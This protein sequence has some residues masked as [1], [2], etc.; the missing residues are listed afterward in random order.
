M[1][2][3]VDIPIDNIDWV[4]VYAAT[5]YGVGTG[6]S[7]QN[8]TNKT[9]YVSISQTKPVVTT[10]GFELQ[11]KGMVEVGSNVGGCWVIV[12]GSSTPFYG[13]ISIFDPAALKV[14]SSMPSDILTT[15][16]NGL[17][18]LKVDNTRSGFIAG[19]EFRVAVE[20]NIPTGGRKVYKIT[21]PIDFIL[22][23]QDLYVDQGGLKLTSFRSGSTTGVYNE[24]V[25]PIPK[26]IMLS[27]PQPPYTSQ[28]SIT[29][30]TTADFT[31]GSL[32]DIVRVRSS[33][34]TAQATS[35]GGNVAV[36]R[37]LAPGDYFI[38]V[39]ALEGVNSASR[40]VYSAVWE[41]RP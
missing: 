39:E 40:G 19:R 28:I 32:T 9:I 25:T 22:W 26:N 29:S 34:A 41:E 21:S 24:V 27:A 3:T 30:G 8:K 17:R 14:V 35:V 1:F 31:G 10:D 7:I 5:G 15:P 11:P 18:R 16:E 20:L 13:L 36:E 23:G 12:H 33:N 37:G 2:S 6:I 4:D 38:V